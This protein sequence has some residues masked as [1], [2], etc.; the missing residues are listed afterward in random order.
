MKKELFFTLGDYG[1]PLKDCNQNKTKPPKS[2]EVT[3]A[4]KGKCLKRSAVIDH[5]VTLTLQYLFIDYAEKYAP[6]EE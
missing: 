2:L 3:Q 4:G 5:N 1:V 6:C